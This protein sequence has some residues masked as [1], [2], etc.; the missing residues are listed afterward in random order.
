MSSIVGIRVYLLVAILLANN[1][2]WFCYILCIYIYRHKLFLFP[3]WQFVME[4][5]DNILDAILNEGQFDDVDDDVEMLDV[6]EGELLD[7][8]SQNDMGQSSTGDIN[9]ANQETQSKNRRRRA[10]KKKNKRKR[11][12]SGSIDINRFP[13]F[14]I[15]R[16]LFSLL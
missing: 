14:L 9:I 6:E 11:K 5:G 3:L 15:G 10:N 2:F 8:D 16:I 4:G 12:V 1:H 7:H 13:L